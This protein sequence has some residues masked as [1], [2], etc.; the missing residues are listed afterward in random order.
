MELTALQKLVL[1]NLKVNSDKN[2][3][4]LKSAS[5][6]RY[7]CEISEKDQFNTLL[8]LCHMGK[9]KIHGT[10]LVSFTFT[11]KA[12]SDDDLFPEA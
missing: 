7:E 4:G 8:Q 3:I 10:E 12:R 11:E 2:G 1:M 9:I 6:M 5:E